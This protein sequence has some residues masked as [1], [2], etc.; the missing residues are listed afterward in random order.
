MTTGDALL[1]YADVLKKDGKVV[2]ALNFANGEHVGGGYLRGA[3]AQEEELCRQFPCMYTT[4]SRAKE[5]GHAY[6]FGACTYEGGRDTKRYADVLFTPRVVA[7]RYSQ[8]EGY[9]VIR[10]ARV[11]SNIAIVSAAA[12]NIKGGREFF[13]P[14]L[15][16]QAMESILLAPKCRGRSIDV[17]ILGAWGCGAFG[18]D[19]HVMAKLFAEVLVKGSN[20]GCLYK[21]IHFA[22]PESRDSNLQIFAEV[23]K[24]EGVPLSMSSSF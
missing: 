21:E 14:E 20:L 7:R 11:L 10:D 24:K 19:P 1:H 6:P 12:P 18:C 16:K 2:C 22:I 15:V 3:R 8:A 17:L 4:L 9:A 23:L 5:Y 13:D